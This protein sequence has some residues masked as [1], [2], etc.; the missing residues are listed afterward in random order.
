MSRFLLWFAIGSMAAWLVSFAL[1]PRDAIGVFTETLMVSLLAL[2][3]AGVWRK[4]VSPALKDT[5]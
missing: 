3:G 2:I 5:E 4:P 1:I